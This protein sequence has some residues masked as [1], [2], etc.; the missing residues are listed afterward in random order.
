MDLLQPQPLSSLGMMN[1]HIVDHSSKKE[2]SLSISV[3]ETILSLKQI[4]SIKYGTNDSYLPNFL[5]LA[6]QDE[7]SGLYKPIEFQYINLKNLFPDPFVA[8]PDK[9]FINEEGTIN[10]QPYWSYKYSILDPD[11]FSTIHLWTTASIVA[12]LVDKANPFQFKGRV[13]VYFPWIQQ[14]GDLFPKNK[15]E[16]R[17]VIGTHR[18]FIDETYKKINSSLEGTFLKNSIQSIQLTLIHKFHATLPP[19][20]TISTDGIYDIF[21]N[22]KTSRHIPFIRYFSRGVVPILKIASEGKTNHPTQ[23]P[24]ALMEYLVNTYTNEGDMVLDNTMGSGTTNLACLKLNRKSIGIEKEKQYYDVAVRRA[25]E[26][27]H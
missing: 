18:S 19:L 15:E 4:I 8:V 27:C 2:F 17:F 10:T 20:P 12:S 25:S 14:L 23:K 21:Y 3:F 24:I 5:F 13:S 1:L 22:M 7:S 26:Y 11:T 16:V 6:T 9:R